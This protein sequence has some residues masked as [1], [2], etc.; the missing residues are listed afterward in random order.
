M[1]VTV[2]F[3]LI[4][5]LASLLLGLFPLPG[6]EWLQVIGN[7]PPQ[8]C[9][10]SSALAPFSLQVL[11][12]SSSGSVGWSAQPVEQVGGAGWAQLSPSTG[13]L[14][15]GHRTIV[16]VIPNVLLCQ[17]V[18]ERTSTAASAGH[19]YTAVNDPS[20]PAAA[21]YH[22]AVT[23]AT[24]HRTTTVDM[25]VLGSAS[26]V[27]SGPTV[28]PTIAPTPTPTPT[29]P[30]IPTP[31][32]TPPPIP[33]HLSVGPTGTTSVNCFGSSVA[34]PKITIGNTGG[35]TMNWSAST[36]VS[37]ASLSS[38]SGLVAPGGS[39]QVSVSQGGPTS[40]AT[41]VNIS[42]N[43]GSATVSFTCIPPVVNFNIHPTQASW[44][45]QTQ[46]QPPAV[47]VTLDNTGSNVAVNWSAA[48]ENPYAGAPL[49]ITS[50]TSG[51]IPA[52]SAGQMTVT[53]NN[54]VDFGS[55]E[56]YTCDSSYGL[57]TTY[58]FDVTVNATIYK[59]AYTI[60]GYSIP[61]A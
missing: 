9:A 55:P 37:G 50:A 26:T 30:P 16:Q 1:R 57:G 25:S 59:F 28:T 39:Q 22:V 3:G 17:Y 11:N 14:A 20:V 60:N 33:A 36:T 56:G 58:T 18:T 7:N 48:A 2:P 24:A 19:G 31:T 6:T 43:G 13:T 49:S 21:T 51:T 23:D 35:K 47:A 8:V 45:C 42:S 15:P 4:L 34:Y 46:G 12:S 38:G 5:G 40:T 44:N 41:N 27:H 10:T 52:T 53:P 61:V 32:P 54:T 29:P